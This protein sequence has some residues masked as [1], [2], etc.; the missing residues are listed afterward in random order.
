MKTHPRDN[1]LVARVRSLASGAAALAG[2]IFVSLLPAYGEALVDQAHSLRSVPADACF[3]SASLRLQEQLDVFLESQAYA[4]LLQVPIVQLAKMQITFQWQQSPEPTVA[5]FRTYYQS[6]EGQQTAALLKEMFSDE[7][8]CYGGA[9]LAD[10]LEFFSELNGLNRMAQIEALA[11]GQPPEEA[12]HRIMAIVLER[13]EKL[14]IPEVVFGFRIKDQDQATRQLDQIRTAV[15]DLFN[16]VRP[17]LST[18]VQ[19]EQIAGHEFV[20]LRLDGTLLPWDEMRTEA[21]EMDEETFNQWKELVSGKKLAVAVGV[22]DEFLLV[23]VG[24]TTEHLEKYGKG[25]LL[26]DLPDFARLNRHAA[27]RITSISYVSTALMSKVN[28]PRRSIND[29]AGLAEVGL[30]TVELNAS[31]REQILADVRGLAENLV[32]YLPEP[33]AMSM[34]SFLTERGGESYQY[35]GGTLGAYDSSQ[36]LTILDH[37]GGNPLLLIASRSKQTVEEYDQTVSWL[38]RVGLDVEELAKQKTPPEEWTDYEK[39]RPRVVELLTRFNATTREHL[40]PALADGQL[41]IVIDAQAKSD[42]WIAQMPPAKEPLPMLEAGLV[43]SVTSAEHLRSGVADYFGI[44]QD[45]IA[46]LHEAHPEEM[47]DVKLPPPQVESSGGATSYNY[48]CPAEWGLDPQIALSAGMT[49]STWAASLSPALTT[50]LIDETPLAI[51]SPL[52]VRRPAAMI[53][54]IQLPKLLEAIRPWVDYG[55]A[56]S[57]AQLQAGDEADEEQ[58]AAGEAAAMMPAG[59][60]LPQVHQLLD[61]LAAVESYTS[62]TYREDDVWVTHSELHVVDLK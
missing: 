13:S 6:P 12:Q 15:V 54:H 37:A 58:A 46:L 43:G 49:E 9:E 10:V 8:F 21:D 19:R 29:L 25:P 48:S 31:R 57:A 41:A 14:T 2:M 23:F 59:F 50:R 47:P 61:V 51:D 36:P 39:W 30:H 60:I 22:W 20:T 38:Q 27:E 5:K 33:A 26:A 53:A 3:Y 17:E 24:D 44:V 11:S 4:R 34:V 52:D 56:V 16:E 7:F 18:H 28:S 55:F 42:R 40:F 62:V 1:H 45:T 32:K 35:R